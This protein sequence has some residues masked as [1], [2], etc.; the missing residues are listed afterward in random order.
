MTPSCQCHQLPATN[1][2][3][4]LQVNTTGAQSV[5]ADLRSSSALKASPAE[6]VCPTYFCSEGLKSCVAQHARA[7]LLQARLARPEG[8]SQF[9]TDTVSVAG[10]YAASMQQRRVSHAAAS[11]SA[12]D[13]EYPVRSRS[14]GAKTS[15]RGKQPP[16]QADPEAMHGQD[17][18]SPQTVLH[19]QLHLLLQAFEISRGMPLL[20]R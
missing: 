7:L 8:Q 1:T 12:P 19:K 17:E 18:I 20:H 5:L 9:S 4:K 14:R 11:T 15:R 3:Y 2:T 6:K 13:Q 16:T 10:S